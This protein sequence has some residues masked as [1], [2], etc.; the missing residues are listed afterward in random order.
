ME[1]RGAADSTSDVVVDDFDGR[2]MMTRGS[3]DGGLLGKS[4]GRHFPRSDDRGKPILGH[5]HVPNYLLLK[6]FDTLLNL[7]LSECPLS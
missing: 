4:N 2:G 1:R 3:V 7:M 6:S 5:N